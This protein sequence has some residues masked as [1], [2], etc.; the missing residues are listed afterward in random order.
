MSGSRDRALCRERPAAIP[1]PN[2]TGSDSVATHRPPAAPR[3]RRV[4]GITRGIISLFADTVFGL[5]SG[6]AFS[7]GET[8]DAAGRS[9]GYAEGRA[10]H[11]AP[12]RLRPHRIR[13]GRTRVERVAPGRSAGTGRSPL[14]PAWSEAGT[15]RSVRP[16][17]AGGEAADRGVVELTVPG[18]RGKRATRSTPWIARSFCRA[19]RRTAIVSSEN[20]LPHLSRAG[21]D[22]GIRTTDATR[23]AQPGS[24]PA[25]EGRAAASRGRM[26]S[27][28]TRA[29][30][31]GSRPA[32]KVGRTGWGQSNG[33]DLGFASEGAA[34]RI[35]SFGRARGNRGGHAPRSGARTCD[36]RSPGRPKEPRAGGGRVSAPAERTA[37]CWHVGRGSPRCEASRS[38]GVILVPTRRF[39]RACPTGRRPQVSARSTYA[40]S[41]IMPGVRESPQSRSE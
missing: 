28:G 35:A 23:P 34:C 29:G 20:L 36:S 37:A 14:P 32:R 2:G 11:S 12:L 10:R 15:Y 7:S 8:R 27:S 16:V 5:R 4:A 26:S 1:S 40:E 38:A 41:A 6:G 24:R 31:A 3:L 39:G 13:D 25:E 18:H 30:R 33:S 21:A 19:M 22:R 17:E 9:A